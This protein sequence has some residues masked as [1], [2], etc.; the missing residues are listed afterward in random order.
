MGHLKQVGVLIKQ[1]QEKDMVNY[2]Q[3]W[4]LNHEI[5]CVFLDREQAF[6]GDLD[7]VIAIGG[8][9]TV[10]FA[11]GAYSCP[12][13]AI[14]SGIVGFLTA[15]KKEDLATILERL[16]TGE[17]IVSERSMLECQYPGGVVT[18]VNEI[19]IKG[20]TRLIST[21]LSINGKH[22][23]TIRGDGV[24]VGTATGSTAYLL[25]AGSPIVMPEIRC[26]I[27]GGLNEHSFT[28]RH[29][30]VSYDSHIQL[31]I[32]PST[33]EHDIY[34]SADGKDKIP[35][36]LCDQIVITESQQRARL[37]FMERNYFFQNLSSHLS[38]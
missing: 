35:L 34:L 1:P 37:I 3:T 9:G 28:A 24:I 20:A 26:M 18:A 6:Q 31:T 25:S 22:I 27:L 14:K 5:Q 8:D 4:F 29:L 17:Y 21:D 16:Y 15:G 33:R 10:L 38:W 2:L 36:S 13:L 32:H 19:V 30:I 12:V 11:L 7:I 23:R